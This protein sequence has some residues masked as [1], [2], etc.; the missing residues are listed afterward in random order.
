MVLTQPG[1]DGKLN[2]STE[3]RS[4]LRA[5]PLGGGQIRILSPS[6]VCG[7]ILNTG[8]ARLKRLCS[9]LKKKNVCDL[10]KGI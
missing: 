7:K 9:C 1:A 6:Q 3:K 2:F 10:P 8:W 4:F 5:A